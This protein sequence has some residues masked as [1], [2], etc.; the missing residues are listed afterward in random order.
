MCLGNIVEFADRDELFNNPLHPDPTIK[1]KQII[2]T[3]EMPNPEDPPSGCKF[4]TRCLFVTVKC[5][6]I[7]PEFREITKGHEI[8]CHLASIIKI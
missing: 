2:L 5:K 6:E 3:G 7:D 8:A 4:H 1:R